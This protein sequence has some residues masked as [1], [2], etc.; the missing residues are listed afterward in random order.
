MR[1]PEAEYNHLLNIPSVNQQQAI[2]TFFQIIQEVRF[3]ASEKDLDSPGEL[4]ST[5][6]L[7]AALDKFADGSKSVVALMTDEVA[8]GRDIFNVGAGVVQQLDPFTPT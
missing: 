7:R 4:T 6:V 2:K 1:S 5:E 3:Q 8:F